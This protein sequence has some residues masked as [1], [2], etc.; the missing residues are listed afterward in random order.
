MAPPAKERAT[1]MQTGRITVLSLIRWALAF[2]ISGAVVGLAIGFF[3]GEPAAVANSM[4]LS[5]LFANAVGFA[6]V[7]S[8]PPSTGSSMSRSP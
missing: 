5:I 3:S 8:A 4:R 6:A 7:L 2:S 1:H